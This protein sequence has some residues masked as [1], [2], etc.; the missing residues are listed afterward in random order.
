MTD[1]EK[2]VR[3]LIEKGWHIAFAESCTAGLCASRLVNVPDASRVLDVS[4]VT[5][6]N[7]AKIKYLG[8]SQ[9]SIE[10]YGVVSEQVAQEMA[11]GAAYAAGAQVGVGVSG[12]AGPGGGTPQKPVGTVCFGFYIDG[13][14]YTFTE[15][16]G[17]LGRN[18]VREKSCDFVYEFLKKQ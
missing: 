12:I 15:H 10:K 7:D 2:V 16:F 3:R 9:E 1:E 8:V 5:Y 18:A 14:V 13:E 17:P 11:R 4:F 6:A